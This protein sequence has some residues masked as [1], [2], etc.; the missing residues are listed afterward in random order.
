MT[1]CLCLWSGIQA[2]GVQTEGRSVCLSV[3]LVHL[4]YLVR[5]VHP[6]KRDRPD[7]QNRPA[8][9]LQPESL[10]AESLCPEPLLRNVEGD[11]NGVC[12]KLRKQSLCLK[13]VVGILGLGLVVQN[14][15]EKI[16]GNVNLS[17]CHGRGAGP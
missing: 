5:L 12:L 13:G 1:G 3:C 2:E 17:C 16:L 7:R 15:L 11:L 8:S 10:Q 9:G 14:R 6:N 4:V